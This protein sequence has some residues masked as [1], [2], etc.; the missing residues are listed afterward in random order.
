VIVSLPASAAFEKDPAVDTG[1]VLDDL[2]G[3]GILDDGSGRNRN[4][5]V[6]SITTVTPFTTAVFP[7][8]CMV[9]TDKLQVGERSQVML[10]DKYD[11]P[12]SAAVATVRAS[13]GNILF[14]SE[15]NTTVAPVSGGN[16]KI[17]LV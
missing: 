3:L 8:F 16:I 10:D 12:A 9:G 5:D 1:K 13:L 4:L 15:G 2:S 11:I 14:P 6:D 17:C 7:V